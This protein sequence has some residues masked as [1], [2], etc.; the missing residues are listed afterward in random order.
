MKTL[1]ICA[2][3]HLLTFK[4]A[5]MLEV[6]THPVTLFKAN[7]AGG[8]KIWLGILRGNSASITP[9]RNEPKL[10]TARHA[11][12]RRAEMLVKHIT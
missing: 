8:E 12:P 7:R 3:Y 2:F 9:D 6:I 5:Q 11:E 1:S 4:T 10:A